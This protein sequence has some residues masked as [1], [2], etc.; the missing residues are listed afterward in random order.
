MTPERAKMSD[1]VM[2]VPLVRSIE[3]L[4]V[5]YISIFFIF[6]EKG[7]NEPSSY[8]SFL[9]FQL[10]WKHW[11]VQDICIYKHTHIIRS[12]WYVC[13]LFHLVTHS[14]VFLLRLC[15][16]MYYKQRLTTA[17]LSKLNLSWLIEISSVVDAYACALTDPPPLLLNDWRYVELW[18]RKSELT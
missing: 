15:S 2:I 6:R 9:A 1:L 11:L 3:Q 4:Y 14:F 7:E 12:R 10:V 13:S 5:I 18:E 8:S 16:Y 17:C